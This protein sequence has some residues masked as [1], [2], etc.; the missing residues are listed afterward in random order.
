MISMGNFEQVKF[1]QPHDTKHSSKDLICNH[2]YY[3]STVVSLDISIVFEHEVNPRIDHTCTVSLHVDDIQRDPLE[4]H[5]VFNCTTRVN[6]FK[7]N[8]D[9]CNEV[10]HVVITHINV[11]H[12]QTERGR[13]IADAASHP[14]A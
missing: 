8:I 12:H 6:L 1:C 3:E 13:Q 14:F 4:M 5:V 9:M 7:D 10:A 11:D 2:A